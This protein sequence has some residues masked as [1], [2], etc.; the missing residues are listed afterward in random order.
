MRGRLCLLAVLLGGAPLVVQAEIVVLATGDFLKVES[1]QV[2][3]G[4]LV[5]EMPFG[6][7]MTLDLSVVE[8]VLEDEILVKPSQQVKSL[9]GI[10]IGFDASQPIPPTPFGASIHS[11][12]REYGLNPRLIAALVKAESSFDPQALSS[13]GAQGLMQIMPATAD[14]FGVA[15]A[16]IFD[17]EVNL[18]TGVRYLSYLRKLY[19][20]E[21]TLMLAA[22]NAGEATVERFGGVPPY[23]ET[24][25]YLRRIERF[26][27]EDNP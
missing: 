13:Q 19:K 21:L 14:R 2:I 5:V 24:Q 11:L 1:H 15:A 6:G 27:H 12:G 7:T 26:Y 10:E 22:Y 18:E 16:E 17:P 25:D 3:D 20:G 4:S 9:P 23:R 8:R